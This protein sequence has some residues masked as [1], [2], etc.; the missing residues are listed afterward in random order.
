LFIEKQSWKVLK[1]IGFLLKENIKPTPYARKPQIQI[2]NN[3]DESNYRANKV[4]ISIVF[5]YIIKSMK[6]MEALIQ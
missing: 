5:M 4:M 2:E 1:W 6:T 3:V